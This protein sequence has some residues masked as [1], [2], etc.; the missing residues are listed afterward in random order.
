VHSWWSRR[1]MQTESELDEDG[2]NINSKRLSTCGVRKL[3][4]WP[5]V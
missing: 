1:S 3:A 2:R 5:H 4:R